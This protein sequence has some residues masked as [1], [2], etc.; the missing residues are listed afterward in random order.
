[1]LTHMAVGDG[2]GAGFEY[3][4]DPPPIDLSKGYIQHPR[5][6]GLPPGCYT[7]DTQM[8]VALA[9]ALLCRTPPDQW[10]PLII[11][12]AFVDGFGRDP[13]EGVAQGF[14]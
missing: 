1:M 10:T 7:D 6:K 5:W 11:A 4:N 3:V 14:Y 2:F 13:R 8:A 12:S 9:E